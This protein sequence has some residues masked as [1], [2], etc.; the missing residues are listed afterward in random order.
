M[1]KT[2]ASLFSKPRKGGIR[3]LTLRDG[4]DLVTVNMTDGTKDIFIGSYKG[5]AIRFNESEIRPMGRTAAG[6]RGIRLGEDD[7]VIGM[8]VSDPSGCIMTVSEKGYGKRTPV[9]EYRE[10]RRGGKGVRN[11]LVTEKTGNVVAVRSV[12]DSDE[13]MLTS[14]AGKLIRTPIGDI[15]VIGRSTQG[16]RIMKLDDGDKVMAVSII[17][18]KDEDEEV[19]SGDGTDNSSETTD[20]DTSK[21]V[22]NADSPAEETDASDTK[23]EES[24]ADPERKE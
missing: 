9:S 22:D 14:A 19:D 12:V 10:T 5:K 23:E 1:K 8:A 11:L 18:E 24:D 4:D 13:I 21:V 15:R 6:V 2:L 7:H 17:P 3:A 20:T 16:V